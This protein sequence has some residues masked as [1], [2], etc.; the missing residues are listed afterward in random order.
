MYKSISPRVVCIVT[1]LVYTRTPIFSETTAWREKFLAVRVAFGDPFIPVFLL[2]QFL[3]KRYPGRNFFEIMNEIFG[4]TVM[5]GSGRRLRRLWHMRAQHVV[6]L[7]RAVRQLNIYRIRR[8]MSWG[9]HRAVLRVSCVQGTLVIG[10]WAAFVLPVVLLF[11]LISCLAPFRRSIFSICSRLLR[12]SRTCWWGC[13]G[14]CIP[15][16]GADCPF[17]P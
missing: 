4:K 14:T 17:F 8:S 10:K 5:E 6:Q 15:G 13:T 16:R 7:L 3:V 11:I 12:I 2:F 1:L 9:C